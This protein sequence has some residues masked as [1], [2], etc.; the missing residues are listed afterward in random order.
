M[1]SKIK[2]PSLVKDKMIF[3]SAD[4]VFK[5]YLPRQWKEEKIKKMGAKELGLYLAQK[6]LDRLRKV[7][8]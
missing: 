5:Y 6:S 7:M 8:G 1:D 3:R 4:T 2:A